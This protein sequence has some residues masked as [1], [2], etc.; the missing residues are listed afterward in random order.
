MCRSMWSL[1]VLLDFYTYVF[2]LATWL[3]N[4]RHYWNQ[5][6][7]LHTHYRNISES[8]LEINDGHSPY[9]WQIL[10][11]S[12]FLPLSLCC[13]SLSWFHCGSYRIQTAVCDCNAYVHSCVCLPYTPHPKSHPTDIFVQRD[14][15]RIIICLNSRKAQQ[16]TCG[17]DRWGEDKGEGQRLVFDGGASEPTWKERKKKKKQIRGEEME[18]DP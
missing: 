12:V 5:S 17:G 13:L 4:S 15:S 7:E 18:G 9:R 2:Q 3:L 14:R 8:S 10:G 1:S 16:W 6:V 11:E